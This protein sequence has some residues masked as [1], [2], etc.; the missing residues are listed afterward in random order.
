M[1]NAA[2]TP[3]DKFTQINCK[4]CENELKESYIHAQSDGIIYTKFNK[5]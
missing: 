1:R 3:G 2:R 5:S 4:L